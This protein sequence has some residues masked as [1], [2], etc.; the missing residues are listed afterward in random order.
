MAYLF[1]PLDD[2]EGYL[3]DAG[4]IKCNSTNICATFLHQLGSLR[5]ALAEGGFGAFWGFNKKLSYRRGTVRHAMTVKTL[6]NVVQMF[7]K[8]L[9]F[10][11][12]SLA[13]RK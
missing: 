11:L 4:L 10:H 5:R 12:I 9:K 8:L 6:L 1:V 7:V 2:F 3:P 13:L